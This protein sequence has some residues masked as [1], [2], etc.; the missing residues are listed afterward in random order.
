MPFQK[1]AI[2]DA[3]GYLGRRILNHLLTISTVSQLTV[4]IHSTSEGL[5]SSPILDV[6]FI[7]SYQDTAALAIALQGHDLLISTLSRLG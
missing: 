6:V 5:P 2:A 7:P 1:I 3:T 4:L